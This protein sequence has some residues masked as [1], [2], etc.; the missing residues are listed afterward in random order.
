MANCFR[1]WWWCTSYHIWQ[2]STA[3]FHCSCSMSQYLLVLFCTSYAQFCLCN[4]NDQ[5]H[6]VSRI[7]AYLQHHAPLS[8]QLIQ[9]VKWCWKVLVHLLVTLY[10]GDWCFSQNCSWLV[11]RCVWC[12]YAQYFASIEGQGLEVETDESMFRKSKHNKEGY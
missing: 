3:Y 4:H 2:I 1:L 8:G 12:V 6:F 7:F 5:L 10:T 9:W 11:Q